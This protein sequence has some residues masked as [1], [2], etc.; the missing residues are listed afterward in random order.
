MIGP[1]Q[2]IP[3]NLKEIEQDT[4][5]MA[6]Y[7]GFEYWGDRL[8]WVARW[9]GDADE[10]NPTDTTADECRHASAMVEALGY[11]IGD[12]FV[13]HDTAYFYVL[14]PPSTEQGN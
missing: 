8:V 5:V 9:V 2:S 12:T 13:D 10:Y 6:D 4:F 14:M 1:Q 7:G 3:E 11:E